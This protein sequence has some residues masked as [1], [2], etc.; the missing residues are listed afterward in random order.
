MSKTLK[1]GIA[2]LGTV[3][4][5]VVKILQKHGGLLAARCGRPVE[6]TAV[7]S[8][9]KG[10]DR[11]IDVSGYEW[12]DSALDLASADVDLIVETIGG[13]EGVACDLV[14]AA[15]AAG[16]H[17][18]TA[19]K[20]LLA[21]HGFELASLAEGNGVS[22]A[23]E[24][25]VAGGIPAIKAVRE[26]LAAN[27]ITAVYGILNGTCNYILTNMR[28]TGRDFEVVLKEAQELGYAEADPTFD[29]D[30]VDAGHKL[31][32][33]ATIAFGIKPNFDAVEMKGIRAL[34]S[35]DIEYAG[36][37]GYKIK[38]LGIAKNIDGEILQSVEPC[39]VPE[40]SPLG[41]IEDVYNAVFVEGDFVETPLLTG[42]GAGQEP[43]ASAVVADVVDLAR[44]LNIPTFGMPAQ[45]LAEAKLYDQ[46]QNRSRYYFRM[47]VLDKPGVIA[48]V[49]AILRDH[50]ISIEGLIQ[51]GRD[52]DQPVPVILTTHGTNY[53]AILDA[54]KKIET[55]DA[56]VESPCLMR[57]E[58]EL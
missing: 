53:G 5:G 36:E 49:S 32:L 51:R 58:D 46:S 12:F 29:V 41:A 15:L 22:L 9:S 8:A 14:K 25:A 21:H 13:S 19:N 26:G 11:G 50:D 33:L 43:T 57:I 54:A 39:L 17:V 42:R 23:Y 37:L 30:G 20:A 45:Q 24:A 18:V 34:S 38:L 3:G 1:I 7:S 31:A 56:S 47:S 52:P 55:L 28:E 44:G 16:K 40:G 48:D 2:G 10:K 35:T 27:E 6:I 4:V